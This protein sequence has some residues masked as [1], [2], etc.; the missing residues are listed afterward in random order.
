M[1]ADDEDESESGGNHN[2]DD[3]RTHTQYNYA[4]FHI[5]FFLATTWVSTLVTMDHEESTKDSEAGFAPVGR[6][7]AA[8][9]IKIVSAWFCY[10]MYIWTLVAPIILPERFDF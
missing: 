7:Y 5:I 2:H 4:V 9:W 1:G 3:E 6:T 8:S 10:C